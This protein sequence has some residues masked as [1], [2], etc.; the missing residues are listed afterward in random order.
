MGL[1]LRR[2]KFPRQMLD[3]DGAHLGVSKTQGSYK[4]CPGQLVNQ[5]K[6]TVSERKVG[7]VGA[8]GVGENGVGA[9]KGLDRA[10]EL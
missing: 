10:P 8:E 9:R 6:E 4:G 7:S 1:G 2:Q 5:K 3:C